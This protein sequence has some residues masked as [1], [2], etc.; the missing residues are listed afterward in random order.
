MEFDEQTGYIAD[1]DIDAWAVSSDSGYIYSGN[2]K[3]DWAFALTPPAATRMAIKRQGHSTR[4]FQKDAFYGQASLTTLSNIILVGPTLRFTPIDKIRLDPGV[5][6]A[7]RQNSD[8]GVYRPGMITV[9]G[10]ISSSGKRL[11]TLYQA[12]RQL[13]TNITVDPDYL[14]YYID[15][16]I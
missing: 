2:R 6:A 10:T 9:P 13:D 1:A 11:G 12:I 7:R 16:A 5:F 3:L 14:F 15:S 8:D 4:S